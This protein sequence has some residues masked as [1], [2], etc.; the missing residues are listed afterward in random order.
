MFLH[1]VLGD[2]ATRTWHNSLIYV[3][4]QAILYTGAAPVFNVAIS[5]GLRR[6]VANHVAQRQTDTP[7]FIPSPILDKLTRIPRFC[8][9]TDAGRI[10][11]AQATC[12]I[13]AA[14]CKVG[15]N[16]SHFLR[17][18]GPQC[19]NSP[20]FQLPL[21]ADFPATANTISAI[22]INVE[23]CELPPYRTF[24]LVAVISAGGL[25]RIV[26]G[27]AKSRPEAARLK[28]VRL[29]RCAVLQLLP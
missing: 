9:H 5:M 4:I 15:C 2:F 29:A 1:Y 7:T 21:L 22:R 12:F 18:L 28:S 20:V 13:R 11:R 16:M 17:Q 10:L 3:A 26:F 8:V 14:T 23:L 19:H 27:T 6:R 25:S 24:R